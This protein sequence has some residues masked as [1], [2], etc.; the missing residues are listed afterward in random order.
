MLVIL[1]VL[2]LA[3][4]AFAQQPVITQHGFR[5][6]RSKSRNIKVTDKA[7]IV[8][9]VSFSEASTGSLAWGNFELSFKVTMGELGSQ[10]AGFTLTFR[11]LGGRDCYA[12]TVSPNALNIQRY[13]GVYSDSTILG[14][15]NKGMQEG[16][17]AEFTIKAEKNRF[18]VYMD[19]RLIIDAVDS[20]NM[21]PYGYITVRSE[22]A[23][24]RF[25]NWVLEALE[26]EDPELRNR[27]EQGYGVPV[28]FTGGSMLEA[29]EGEP[30][31]IMLVYDQYSGKNWMTVDALPY[32]TYISAE[33]FQP[34][35]WFFDSFLFLAL[36]T[37]G[38]RNFGGGSPAIL[39]D[40]FWWLDRMF[41]SEKLGLGAFERAIENNKAILGDPEHKANVIMMI[42]YP[43]EIEGTPFGLING[44][45]PVLTGNHKEA[46]AGRLSVVKWWIDEVVKRFNENNYQNLNLVGFYWLAED[47]DLS[48]IDKLYLPEVGEI[49]RS[50]DMKFYW[51]PWYMSPGYDTWKDLGFDA[52][53]MQPN[54]MFDVDISKS[55]LLKTAALAEKYNLGIEIEAD[56]TVFTPKGKER[57][58]NYL[59]AA[60]T[61]GW[62]SGVLKAIYQEVDLLGR[63]ASSFVPEEREIYDITYDFIN[64]NYKG[65]LILDK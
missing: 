15:Y 4:P 32:V 12:L 22:L 25:E 7:L 26:I 53:I 5:E 46:A 10:Y 64:G 1:L 27:A 34:Q 17:T 65:K 51:I 18:T 37:P 54:Y 23:S 24:L 28:E 62:A 47:L 55:R 61:N 14:S 39:E 9:T 43:N 52:S 49:V 63:A 11:S 31:N 35:D 6:F 16:E 44:K 42:P 57:Y 33:T 13:Y 21:Y 41:A 48:G 58:F 60:N 56:S 50:L 3:A 30:Q 20:Q 19:G 2:L 29:K 40:Y 8:D 45:K 36:S 38:G 59:R